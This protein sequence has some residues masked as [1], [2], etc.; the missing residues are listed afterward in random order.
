MTKKVLVLLSGGIDSTY[1]AYHLKEQGFFVKGLV[2]RIYD[3]IPTPNDLHNIEI[4]KNK[5]G[6]DVE[7]Q[8]VRDEFRKRIINYFLSTYKEGKTPNPCARCNPEIK[9]YYAIKTL[10]EQHFNFVASG[11]YA[12]IG[13]YKG[14]LTL[15]TSSDKT[16]SQE[17]FLA[18][19]PQDYLS[20]IIFP[21]AHVKKEFIKKEI[22][23]LF[24]T[25]LS[26]KE[27]Q[28]V[29][30]L[31]KEGVKEFLKRYHV[32]IKGKMVYKNT[33]VKEGIDILS[34]TRGQRRGIDFAA[35]HRVYVKDI[36]ITNRAI[37]L[38]ERK[39]LASSSFTINSPIFYVPLNEIERCS[40]KVRYSKN[41]V[42]CQIKK[43]DEH[44]LRVVL[45][46]PLFTI[47]EGQLAVFY[48]NEY[49]LGS[50]WI[51]SIF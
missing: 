42:P 33:V 13:Q 6:F 41:A 11:H 22:Q 28:D 39:D 10:K 50:G 26:H 20:F 24:P 7:I 16:K 1:A 36:D 29:C 5:I 25:L 3:D 4:I 32:E 18:R 51:D 17:Y 8:D 30:F 43:I 21:L 27:S 45:K 9:F 40:V 37:E 31:K 34:Y 47:T 35:G 44:K 46:K 23:K 48:D 14:Y 19:I 49:V 12:D 2:L 38:G 15:K